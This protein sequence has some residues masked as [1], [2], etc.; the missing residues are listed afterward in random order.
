MQCSHEPTH[1]ARINESIGKLDANRVIIKLTDSL[2]KVK[3]N[4]KHE[5]DESEKKFPLIG[6]RYCL[7]ILTAII[8]PLF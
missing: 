2:M 3:K 4:E 5:S 1:K 6:D 7:Y 8:F